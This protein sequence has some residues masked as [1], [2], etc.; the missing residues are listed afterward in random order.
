MPVARLSLHVC[1]NYSC[2]PP[3]GNGQRERLQQRRGWHSSGISEATSTAGMGSKREQRGVASFRCIISFNPCGSVDEDY[4]HLQFIDEK[5]EAQR[6][7]ATGPSH[8]A[9][10]ILSRD[11]HSGLSILGLLLNPQALSCPHTP[12]S[13]PGRAQVC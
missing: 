1:N 9:L 7:N 3:V 8:T 12:F 2:V 5:T 13:L 6:G 10:K 4:Y 11:T